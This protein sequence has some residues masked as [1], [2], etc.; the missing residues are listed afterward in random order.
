M[1]LLVL[2]QVKEQ[3]KNQIYK[4]AP[5]K[6]VHHLHLRLFTIYMDKSVWQRFVQ[7]KA[8]MP[9]AMISLDWPFAIYSKKQKNN[10]H[11]IY[12]KRLRQVRPCQNSSQI[13]LTIYILP[14]IS[15]IY[16]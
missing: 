16:E 4:Y 15:S 11:K 9:D 13:C 7:M 8:K 14:E 1:Q 3:V 2:T 10:K 6:V 12:R 5:L